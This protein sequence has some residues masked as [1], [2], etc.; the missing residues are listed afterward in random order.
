V[1]AKASTICP[2]L[3]LET[4]TTND[5]TEVLHAWFY[6]PS[7]TAASRH[8]ERSPTKPCGI[9]FSKPIHNV[10]DGSGTKPASGIAAARQPLRVQQVRQTGCLILEAEN[11]QALSVEKLVEPNGIEPLT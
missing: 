8:G 4:R 11:V 1:H 6:G 10:K 5:S 3:T 9:R 7:S 2:Y